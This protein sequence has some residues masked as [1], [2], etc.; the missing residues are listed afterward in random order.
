M[1]GAP[2]SRQPLND[3]HTG[4]VEHLAHG[5]HPQGHGRIKTVH[6]RRL[7]AARYPRG[8]MTEAELAAL[9]AVWH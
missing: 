1:T 8:L 3:T 7:L 9:I 2:A 6:L 5:T 4:V